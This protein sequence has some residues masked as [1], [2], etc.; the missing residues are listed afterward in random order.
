MI[1]GVGKILS[2]IGLTLLTAL[3]FSSE[4]A[5]IPQH[6]PVPKQSPVIIDKNAS[7]S[8]QS[9]SLMTSP[10]SVPLSPTT[11]LITGTS[12][13]AISKITTKQKTAITKKILPPTVPII[14]EK[15]STASTSPATT[16]KNQLIN[17]YIASLP[18]TIAI[19]IL[20]EEARKALVNIIC[21]SDSSG[22]FEP[23]SGSGIIIS[24]NGAVLTNAHIAQYFLLKKENGQPLL[25]CI[26]RTG[27]PAIPAYRADLLYIS[28]DWIKKNAS[29]LRKEIHLGTGESDFALLRIASTTEPNTPVPTKFSY[30]SPTLDDTYLSF[31]PQLLIAAYPAGFLGGATIQRELYSATTIATVSHIMTFS[32]STNTT[33]IIGLGGS[34]LAQKGSSGG[35]VIDAFGRLAGIIV[36]TTMEKS[37]A[38]RDLQ[39]I[40]ISHIDRE[41]KRRADFGLEAMLKGNIQSLSSQFNKNISPILT[42]YLMQQLKPA[43]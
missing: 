1:I 43:Y 14:N 22:L 5:I 3:G 18:K 34:V 16:S 4:P 27:S 39:A 11:T 2:S 15:N 23:L 30:I 6:N 36:T 31:G 9:V 13:P 25:D 35:G 8:K 37:T 42:E 26:L 32:S 21:T 28:P 20:N 7:T 29:D 38:N 12:S 40:T 19:N 24:P 10:L 17:T 41:I 33:D